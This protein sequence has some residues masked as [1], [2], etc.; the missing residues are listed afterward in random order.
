MA[1]FGHV[2]T[3]AM[4]FLIG[5]RPDTQQTDLAGWV[6]NYI[7]FGGSPR[8]RDDAA[9]ITFSPRHEA[10]A[11]TVARLL[12]PVWDAAIVVRSANGLYNLAGP[13][14]L[15]Q[16]REVQGNLEH[17]RRFTDEN[18]F[19][20]MQADDDPSARRAWD[21]E[22]HSVH[23]LNVLVKQALEAIAFVQLLADYK[24]GDVVAR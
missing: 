20:R 22:E 6:S 10:Y 2:Q 8:L 5:M 3:L 23:A 9:Q 1:S 18:H 17:L 21:Q 16:L 15:S 19:P 4:A 11:L 24:L 12:R 13:H 7:T 14:A